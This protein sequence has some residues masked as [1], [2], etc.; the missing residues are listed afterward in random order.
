MDWYNSSSRRSTK[1]IRGKPRSSS[2]VKVEQIS[3]DDDKQKTSQ[4]NSPRTFENNQDDTES[5]K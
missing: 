5:G 3:D 4:E 2:N 1:G